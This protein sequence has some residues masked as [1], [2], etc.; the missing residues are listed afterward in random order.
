LEDLALAIHNQSFYLPFHDSCGLRGEDDRTLLPV[1][2]PKAHDVPGHGATS[3]GFAT[4]G[5]LDHVFVQ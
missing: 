5:V 3:W 4:A 1:G 2:L